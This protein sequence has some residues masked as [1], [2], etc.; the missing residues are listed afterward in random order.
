LFPPHVEDRSYWRD[1]WLAADVIKLLV[2]NAF[3]P[4][5]RD[6]EYESQ[7]NIVFVRRRYVNHAA[8]GAC[9]S[10]YLSASAHPPR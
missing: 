5:A 6:Y 8:F 7:Y 9:Y 2:E 1:Q 10:R 3:L 4:V